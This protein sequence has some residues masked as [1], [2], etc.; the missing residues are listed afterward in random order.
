MRHFSERKGLVPVSELIQID[1]MNSALKNSIWNVLDGLI[2]HRSQFMR[3]YG[4][5]IYPAIYG[6]SFSSLQSVQ[7]SPTRALQATVQSMASAVFRNLER[8]YSAIALGK[9]IVIVA[10]EFNLSVPNC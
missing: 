8:S 6:L 1:S 9:W 3:G 5:P 10:R 4:F 7:S 2:W